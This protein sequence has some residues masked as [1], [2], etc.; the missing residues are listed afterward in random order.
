MKRY[1]KSSIL[2]SYFNKFRDVI[3]QYM[4]PRG[5][6]DNMA[7]QTVTAVNKLIYK[8][9]NDGDVYDNTYGMQGWAND[10]SSYANWLAEYVPDGDY[11][12]DR[13]DQCYNDS[14]YEDLLKDLAEFYL[15]AD[16]LEKLAQYPAEG[17]IYDCSGPFKFS[18][19]EADDDEWEEEDEYDDEDDEEDYE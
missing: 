13:I 11:I 8:W 10:L 6:G 19:P 17:S 4:P 14:Q 5:E 9:Y 2:W 3:N 16:L 15:D 7:S 18:D 1:I 12:L